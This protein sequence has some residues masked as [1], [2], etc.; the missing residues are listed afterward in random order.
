M[1]LFITSKHARK[2]AK[3][4]FLKVHIPV[5]EHRVLELGAKIQDVFHL[6]REVSIPDASLERSL[7]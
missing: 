3:Q 7:T 4:E 5:P 2:E 6:L 1:R